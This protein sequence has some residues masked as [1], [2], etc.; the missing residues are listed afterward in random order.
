MRSYAG[1]FVGNLVFTAICCVAGPFFLL[2]GL[3]TWH[4]GTDRGIA[5]TC[6]GIGLAGTVTIPVAAFKLTRQGFPRITRRDRVKGASVRYDDDTLVMLTPESPQGPAR[7]WLARADVLEASLAHYSPD[8]EATF[9]THWGDY[10][11]DEFTPLI[12]LRLRVHGVEGADSFEVT[13]EWRVPSMC[14]SAVTAGRLVV[15]VHPA[16]STGPFASSDTA[17][18]ADPATPLDTAP[19]APGGVTPPAASGKVTAQW[20]RSLLLAGTRTS[21]LLDLD[22]H[23]T[24]VT[25]RPGRL[26]EQ[27]RIS[28]AAGGVPMTGD[29]IDL[30]RLDPHTAG[31]YTALADRFHARPEDRAPVTEPGEESRW[32]VDELPG[33]T[34]EFGSA[35]RRWSRRGGHLIRARFVELRGTTTF[36]DHGPVLDTVVRIQPDDGT[37]PF[38]AARRLTLPMN[39]LAVLHRTRDVVLCVAP[40]GTSYVVDWPRTNLL[41]GVTPAKVITPASAELPLTGRPDLIW[42]LMTL[43]AAHGVSAPTP[44]LDLRRPRMAPI[45][46][47]ALR[48]VHSALPR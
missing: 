16:P 8:G 25:R 40:R 20:P 24:D 48:I 44:T 27:M 3:Q 39:Y 1:A 45:V 42:P 21:R 10:T 34:G 31:R 46:P 6:V 13:Q 36:Q 43:L 15:L 4:D 17:S 22:G 19:A 29:T 11:P 9:T 41:A 38:D 14:L 47:F 32:I 35:G 18:F 33:C 26:L 7:A 5:L 28:R 37:P 12:R 30:G 23:R 2:I